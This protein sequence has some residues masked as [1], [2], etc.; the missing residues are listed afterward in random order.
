M[1]RSLT[2]RSTNPKIMD[3][4]IKILDDNLGKA[5]APDA[6]DVVY[7]NTDSGL[8]ADDVQSAIDELNTKITLVK[9]EFTPNYGASADLAARNFFVT[10]NLTFIEAHFC[11]RSTE[12]I[13]HDVD[14]IALP[15]IAKNK[16]PQYGIGVETSNNKAH[17]VYNSE[18]YIYL[19]GSDITADSDGVFAGMIRISLL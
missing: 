4:N 2:T 17:I 18:N 7:D 10:D 11:L 6:E 19:D 5:S 16:I 8:T 13:T 3:D 12:A 9:T 14:L 1:S 15:N